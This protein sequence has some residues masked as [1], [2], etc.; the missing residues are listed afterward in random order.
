MRLVQLV[1]DRAAGCYPRYNPL[2]RRCPYAMRAERLSAAVADSY[3]LARTQDARMV[4]EMLHNVMHHRGV[5]RN[6]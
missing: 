5:E 6:D 4:P 1:R 2:V 3:V